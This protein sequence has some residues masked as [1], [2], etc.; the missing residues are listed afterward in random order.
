MLALHQ[1]GG[2][3]GRLIPVIGN[4]PA[5]QAAASAADIANQIGDAELHAKAV[6]AHI[7]LA[8]GSLPLAV[9]GSAVFK[10]VHQ[11]AVVPVIGL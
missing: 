2:V 7:R 8:V 5:A 1:Y 3:I 10:L 9:P 4:P 6:A 11:I